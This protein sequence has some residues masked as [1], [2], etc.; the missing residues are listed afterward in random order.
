MIFYL[1]FS[2]SL[3]LFGSLCSTFSSSTSNLV[4]FYL[5]S[6][7]F[8]HPLFLFFN[9]LFLNS[10]PFFSFHK[11]SKFF[12]L[13][14]KSHNSSHYFSFRLLREH[15][16]STTFFHLPLSLALVLAFS[17]FKPKF[18]SSQFRL[19]LQVCFGCPLLL[20]PCG[21]HSSLCLVIFPGTFRKV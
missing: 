11:K 2:N 6:I 8:Y 4:V 19:L 16:A 14:S 5:I 20:F 21:F 17:H 15:K 1:V 3:F 7:K 10:S 13:K 18:R 12:Y 9:S